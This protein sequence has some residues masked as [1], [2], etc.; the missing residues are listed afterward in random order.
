MTFFNT[1]LTL[2][3]LGVILFTTVLAGTLSSRFGFPALIGF[4]GLG[5]LAGVDGPGGFTSKI[6]N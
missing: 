5:M 2:L 6:S 1:E 3:V 4:L